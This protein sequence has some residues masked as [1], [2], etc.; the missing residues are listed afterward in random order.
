MS[1]SRYDYKKLLAAVADPTVAAIRPEKTAAKESNIRAR[2]LRKSSL[3]ARKKRHTA[4]CATI[5]WASK[6][7]RLENSTTTK[8]IPALRSG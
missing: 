7:I 6:S 1:A 3:T 5:R 8:K 4:R 2:W